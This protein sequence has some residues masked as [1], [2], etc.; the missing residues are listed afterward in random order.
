MQTYPSWLNAANAWMRFSV[1]YSQM[2]IAAAEVVLRRSIMM[3]Q[4]AMSRPEAIGM[5]MEKASAFTLAA[6]KA[7]VASARGAD[8]L[9]VANAALRPIRSRT[10]S[11]A[12]RLRH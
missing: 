10:R 2:S 7:A 9:K 5:V 3:S 11:N 4:G 1:A 6:E 12:R 8:P